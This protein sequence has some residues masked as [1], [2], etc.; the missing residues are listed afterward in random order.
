MFVVRKSESTNKTIRMP[1]ELIKELD[2]VA[3]ETD[4][5]FS[6]LVIQ[7]CEYALKNIINDKK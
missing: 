7:C 3:A 1:N 6:R 2:K 4:V 5:S